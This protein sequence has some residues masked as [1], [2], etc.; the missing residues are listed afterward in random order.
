MLRGLRRL[1][2]WLR[3]CRRRRQRQLCGVVQHLPF[4]RRKLTEASGLYLPLTCLGRHSAQRLDRALHRLLAVR[5]KPL[6]LRIQRPELLFLLRR[7][8][9]P[10]FHA[11]QNL[12][13][14]V[15]RHAVETLQTLLKFL[16]T[17]GRQTLELRIALQCTLLL[18]KRLLTVLVQPLPGMMSFCRR[19]VRPGYLIFPLRRWLR[20]KLR[21]ALRLRPLWLRTS[22]GARLRTR[23]SLFHG[24]RWPLLPAPLLPLW[25]WHRALLVPTVLG[26]GRH[27]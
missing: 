20:L 18:I 23:R 10:G 13:L 25:T 4:L 7:Q 27:G 14:T 15:C 24:T 1:I 8:V 16:L 19:L 3:A 6:E 11:T 21:L 22:F 12:L 26:E 2:A 17:I 5:R 9:L